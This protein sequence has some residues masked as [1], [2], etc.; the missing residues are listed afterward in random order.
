VNFT[1]YLVTQFTEKTLRYHPVDDGAGGLTEGI[2]N[3]KSIDVGTGEVHS[4]AQGPRGADLVS[5]SPDG[6]WVQM[7]RNEIYGYFLMSRDG[8]NFLMLE[9][10]LGEETNFVGWLYKPEP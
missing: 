10:I 5:I 4:I 3:I 1:G 6:N 2:T 9:D 8:R 7:K